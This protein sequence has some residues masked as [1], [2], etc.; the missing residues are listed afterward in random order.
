MSTMTMLI[1]RLLK[2]P[3]HAQ[4]SRLVRNPGALLMACWLPVEKAQQRVR[5]SLEDPEGE[6]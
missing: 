6:A 3:L 5:A 4:S 2:S 1:N